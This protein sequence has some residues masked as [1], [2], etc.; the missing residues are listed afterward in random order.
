MKNFRY[1]KK[2]RTDLPLE[3]VLEGQSWRLTGLLATSV[4]LWVRISH[5]HIPKLNFS[6]SILSLYIK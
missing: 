1:F 3:V 4:A 5:H 6:H 2:P